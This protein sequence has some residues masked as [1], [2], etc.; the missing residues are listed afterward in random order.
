MLAQGQ[1]RR[2]SIP[3]AA[4]GEVARRAP[5]RGAAAAGAAPAHLGALAGVMLVGVRLC[6]C[7]AIRCGRRRRPRAFLRGRSRSSRSPPR[8]P[9]AIRSATCGARP[10]GCVP[11]HPRRIKYL[12]T[13]TTRDGTLLVCLACFLSMT[14]F[15]YSQSLFAALAALPAVVLVGAALDVTDRGRQ[16]AVVAGAPPSG[17]ARR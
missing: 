5:D 14:P 12:E 9:C 8:S 11:V 13:R 1:G 3:V 17:A 4:A 15:F 6:C 16:H 10:V 7:G 2:A